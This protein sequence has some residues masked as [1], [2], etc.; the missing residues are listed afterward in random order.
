M[1]HNENLIHL[2]RFGPHDCLARHLDTFARRDTV[3]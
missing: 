2:R 1:S 3:V